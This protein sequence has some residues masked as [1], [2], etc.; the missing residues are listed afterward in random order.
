MKYVLLLSPFL[1][2]SVSNAAPPFVEPVDANIVNTPTVDANIINTPTVTQDTLDF[3]SLD[4]YVTSGTGSGG[5]FVRDIRIRIHAVTV[6]IAAEQTSCT[7]NA[8]V[9]KSVGGQLVN[10]IFLATANTT[11]FNSNSSSVSF[12]APIEVQADFSGAAEE[13]VLRVQSFGGAACRNAGTFVYE[14][15]SL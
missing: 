10:E 7:V 14:S 5:R 15:E 4:S 6:S 13:V 1:L 8:S 12:T 11:P 3:D 9:R 2:A